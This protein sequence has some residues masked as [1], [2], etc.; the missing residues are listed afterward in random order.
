MTDRKIVQIK[1]DLYG[2]DEVFYGPIDGLIDYLKGLK[3][4]YPDVKDLKIDFDAG[5]N[6]VEFYVIGSRLENDEEYSQRMA[7]E[8]KARLD[9]E[10]RKQKRIEAMKKKSK[11]DKQKA[12]EQFLELKAVFEPN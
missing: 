10:A 3:K 12:Y 1:D 6:N 9:A 2:S 8:E 11:K 7:A 4:F 5:Y